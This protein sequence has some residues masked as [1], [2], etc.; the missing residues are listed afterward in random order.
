MS[1]VETNKSKR[2]SAFWLKA[3]LIIALLIVVGVIGLNIVK[4]LRMKWKMESAPE[5]SSP[6]TAMTVNYQEWT[7]VI[8]T[9][10]LIRPNQ[11]AMLSA[12]AAGTV[13]KILVVSGQK[14]KKGDLLVELDSEV[15]TAT[16]KASEAQLPSARLTYQR[17]A[18]LFRSKSV[19]QQELDNAKATYDELTA[20]ISALK[21][22]IE[23]RR[24]L[25]PFDG[26]T[27]IVQVNE[28]QYVTTGTNIV[29]VEDN[30]EM[31]VDFSISQNNLSD[32]HIGQ[33]VTATSDARPGETFQALVT[34]IEPAI[35]KSTGLVD[36]Q[37][38]FIREDGSKLLSG[39]FTRLRL[40]LPTEKNQIIVPQVAI[41]YNMY[42]ELAYV[43]KP[44]SDED[45][46]KLEGNPAL[47][48][49]YRAQQI[50]VFTKDRQG[51]Y[52]QLK[53]NDVK[54]G[55]KIVTGGQQRLSNGSLV[56]VADK[57]GVGT[58]QPAEKTNL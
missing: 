54:A 26:V 27:G 10:G 42:G 38:T 14:V 18:N 19:S 20:N 37:A 24:I 28:G 8:E 6:V 48:K 3:G 51:I 43:L 15:E 44:L 32:L 2:A 53:G 25:A 41:T 46:A 4:G 33:K 35:N 13:K 12:E 55:D 23:R 9:T 34:A 17:Y 21:A 5:P 31:K 52:A 56:V 36:V 40:A 30:S 45:K 49:M 58:S 11:G 39:M 22:S 50:T 47:D 7:P 57:E 1:Q 16:L 29:R